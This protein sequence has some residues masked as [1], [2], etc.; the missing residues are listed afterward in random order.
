MKYRNGKFGAF[1]ARLLGPL[2]D[3]VSVAGLI[4]KCFSPMVP[5]SRGFH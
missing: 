2:K 1:L 4:S 3:E 5:I